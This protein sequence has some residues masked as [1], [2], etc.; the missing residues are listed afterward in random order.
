MKNI[1]VTGSHRSGTTWIGQMLSQDKNTMYVY[2]PFN[3]GNYTHF[4]NDFSC[5][6]QDIV[7]EALSD[8][9]SKSV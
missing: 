4:P 6:C 9:N 8:K 3:I 1:L 2:E 5:W 7:R